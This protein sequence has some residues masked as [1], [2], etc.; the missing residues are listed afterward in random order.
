MSD[1][2]FNTTF[3]P[4]TPGALNLVSGQTHGSDVDI[5]GDTILGSVIGDPQPRLDDCSTREVVA[6]NRTN[7]GDLPNSK[8]IT[9]GWFQG[10]FPPP[11]HPPPQATSPAPPQ[12]CHLNPRRA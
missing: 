6:M 12:A 7:V 1:N 10:G 4:S 3:G 8:G 9:W 11:A 5:A 2:S